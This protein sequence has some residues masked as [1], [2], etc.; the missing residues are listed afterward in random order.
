MDKI[1]IIAFVS[2]AFE[3]PR[4]TASSADL[5][6]FAHV[7]LVHVGLVMWKFRRRTVATATDTH[8]SADG[9]SSTDWYTAYDPGTHP[10]FVP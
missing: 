6:P 8:R 3:A 4:L 5:S 9:R 2:C 7:L 10:R 1:I